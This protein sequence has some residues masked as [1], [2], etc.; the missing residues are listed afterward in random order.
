[1]DRPPKSSDADRYV[2]AQQLHF[3]TAR[4]TDHA[5]IIVH[6]DGPRQSAW[7][8]SKHSDQI[9][10][11]G[12]FLVQEFGPSEDLVVYRSHLPDMPGA[13][14]EAVGWFLG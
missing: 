2:P 7:E 14:V 3:A 9:H 8:R 12:Q 11:V 4:P 1:M 6:N 10:R 13:G 5:D